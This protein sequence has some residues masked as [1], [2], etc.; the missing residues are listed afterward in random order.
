MSVALHG[1]LKNVKLTRVMNGVVA[2]TS[3]QTGSSV[4]MAGF[5]G[6]VFIALLGDLTASQVTSLKAQCSSDDGSADTFADI[7]GSDSG[8]MEDNDDNQMIGL[9][10]ID[11]PERYVRP[12]LLRHTA[13]AV[14][15]GILALQY[16]AKKVPV[17]HDATTVFSTETLA[18]PAEGTA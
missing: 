5:E 12:I 6:V 11:P 4:D 9:D 16:G 8:N 10:I 13:N 2:G 15:D 18:G 14:I 7:A 17:T 3:D 1:L